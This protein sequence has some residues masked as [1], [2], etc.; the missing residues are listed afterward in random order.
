MIL[1]KENGET[2]ISKSTSKIPGASTV[3]DTNGDIT[4]TTKVTKTDLNGE[5]FE[6]RAVSKTL[7]S[8]ETYTRYEKVNLTTG[9]TQ[10]L[11][12]TISDKTPFEESNTVE[13]EDIDGVGL[14]MKVNTKVTRELIIE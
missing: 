4:T 6:I 9:E 12:N 14:Q 8:G 10:E 7:T 13:I 5:Q 11:E 1:T 2:I 3:L